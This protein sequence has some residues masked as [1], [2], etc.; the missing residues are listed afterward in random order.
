MGQAPERN[1]AINDDVA[2]LVEADI[3]REVHTHDW[4]S[5]SVLVKN[6]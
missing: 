1:K 6:K 4:Q 3:M 2:K 5:N